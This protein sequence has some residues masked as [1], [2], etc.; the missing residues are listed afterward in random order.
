MSSERPTSHHVPRDGDPANDLV[1]LHEVETRLKH[2]FV[3]NDALVDVMLTGAIA[4][5]PLL[6]LGPPGTAK[7]NVVRRFAELCA[8]SSL[9]SYMLTRFTEPEELFGPVDLRTLQYIRGRDSSL[10]AADIVFLDEVFKG[11]SSVLNA[12]L[13]LLDGSHQAFV[14]GSAHGL[15]DDSSL[16]TF[17]DRFVLRFVSQNVPSQQLD[18][19]MRIAWQAE[20][21]DLRHGPGLADSRNIVA[22]GGLLRL[23][24]AIQEVSL[25]EAI[26]FI[27][28]IVTRIRGIGIHVSDRRVSRIAKLVAA[29]AVRRGAAIADRSDCWICRY[30]WNDAHEIESLGAL[31]DGFISDA[32][33][34]VPEK[35]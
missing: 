4:L 24:R 34:P 21:H 13:S 6:I 2:E 32:G 35:S 19:F 22:A 27:I 9:F 17:A 7:S 29:S 11:S 33:T 30:V 14:I 23:H 3:G 20:R 16:R 10:E 8:G 1:R 25:D 5:E 15:P 18:D 28:D 26:K 31:I 12:L